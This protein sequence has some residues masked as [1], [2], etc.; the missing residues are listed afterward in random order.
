VGVDDERWPATESASETGSVTAPQADS[1]TAPVSAP[2]MAPIT[3]SVTDVDPADRGLS[4]NLLTAEVPKKPPL[5]WWIC[6]AIG[7]ASAVI[8]L[9]PWL[10]HGM[11]LPLQLFWGSPATPESMPIV[12]L[13]F[14]QYAVV[15]LFGLLLTGAAVAGIASR[16]TR[17]WQQRAG[18]FWTILSLLAVQIL[19]AVQT[20][21][22]VLDGAANRTF[23]W[24][25]VVALVGVIVVSI[26]V[27]VPV[28]L[29]IADAPRAGATIGL[30]IA[31][32]A[33]TAWVAGLLH[34]VTVPP[35]PAPA[36]LVTV[37]QWLPAVLVGL[38]LAWGGLNTAGRIIAAPVCLAILWAGPV[39]LAVIA[40]AAADPAIVDFPDQ[41]SERAR[42]SLI[43]GLASV[44]AISQPII[45]ALAVAAAGLVVK[46]LWRRRGRTSRTAETRDAGGHASAGGTGEGEA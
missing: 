17:P 24:L 1:E 27:G 21:L 22:V 37:L 6:L 16:A 32:L 35:E 11:R 34:P 12:L 13:P 15:L 43:E 8:G 5:K 18:Q 42:D 28:L 19:A 29:L 38:A 4:D 36:V 25:Y 9:L 2:V 31:A 40:V 10:I 3:R 41:V 46:L 23:T 7:V 20:T 45:V 33:A 14:S 39:V 30:S 26:L 44:D